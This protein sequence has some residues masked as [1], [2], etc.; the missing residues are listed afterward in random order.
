[1]IKVE[2]LNLKSKRENNYNP[3]LLSNSPNSI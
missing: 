3:F 2:D 1:M